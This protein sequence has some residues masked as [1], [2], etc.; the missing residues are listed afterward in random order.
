LLTSNGQ[1]GSW[2]LS[3]TLLPPPLNR[4]GRSP[5]PSKSRSPRRS[6]I[7]RSPN[8]VW[9]SPIRRSPRRSPPRRSPPRHNRRSWSSSS[10]EDDRDARSA[11]GPFTRRICDAQIPRDLEKL[12]Q[13]DSYDG[14]TDPDEHIDV[15]LSYKSVR[16]TVKCK[17]FITTLQRG[18]M[19]WFKDPR[20]NSIDSLKVCLTLY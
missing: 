13:M 17:L 12:P 2:P 14:T 20:R 10:S 4:R 19:T 16:G 15:V 9:R 11:Y 5:R 1:K 7:V 3:A 8:H 6:V 18:A